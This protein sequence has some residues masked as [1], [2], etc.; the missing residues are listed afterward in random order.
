[1]SAKKIAEG[2]S[3]T[4]RVK[5]GL[6][7]PEISGELSFDPSS[8]FYEEDASLEAF[9]KVALDL[10]RNTEIKRKIFIY[11]DELVLSKF[12]IKSDEYS[13]RIALIKDL[14][15][16]IDYLNEFFVRFDIAFS[17]ICSLRPNIRDRIIDQNGELSKVID[18]CGINLEWSGF[19]P[20][21]TMT[22]II[23]KK[24]AYG[25]KPHMEKNEIDS[26]L[27]REIRFGRKILPFSD[28]ILTNTWCKPR[29]I[30]RLLKCC[31][32]KGPNE[33]TISENLLKASLNEYSRISVV[34]IFDE[35]STMYDRS[36]VDTLRRRI[37][38]KS[39]RDLEQLHDQIGNVGVDFHALC[40]NLFD[41]GFI[42]NRARGRFYWRH[43][44]EDFLRDDMEI[45]IHPGLW[46]YF[47]VR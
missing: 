8:F 20:A 29:D 46:N 39:Y 14:I 38:K 27:P 31:A 30:I 43:R 9:N 45:V 40:E 33:T 4:L 22:D 23:R 28:F 1:M 32:G 16:S 7:L 2:I 13:V 10:L 24:I 12:N 35:I 47:N 42:G 6:N 17:I 15:R 11:V 37:K 44:G 19:K 36:I 41:I 5:I 21:D 34:E 3:K 26:I 25:V 18:G